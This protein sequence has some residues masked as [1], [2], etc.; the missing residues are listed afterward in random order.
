MKLCEKEHNLKLSTVNR[1]L[2]NIHVCTK[3]DLVLVPVDLAV[4]AFNNM[5]DELQSLIKNID[6]GVDDVNEFVK[7]NKK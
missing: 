5:K 7:E 1:V 4:D 2:P 3:C 6:E